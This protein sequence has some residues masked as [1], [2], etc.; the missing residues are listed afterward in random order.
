MPSFHEMKYVRKIREKGEYFFLDTKLVVVDR[1]PPIPVLGVAG[2][3]VK[4]TT[5]KRDQIF[6]SGGGLIENKGE[7]ETAPSSTFL[8][9]LNNH[10]LVYCKEVAGA[11]TISNFQSTSQKFM[12][13]RHAEFVNERYEEAKLER[14]LIPESERVSK[15][16][17]L[18]E[19]PY[20]KLRVT[21]LS[22]KESLKDFIARLKHIDSLAITLLPTNDE[23]IDNDDFWT[24]LGRRRREMNSKNAKVNFSNSSEGL[25]GEKVYE[26]AKAASNLA[27]SEVRLKGHD[28][29]G[30][31]LKGTNEDF[32]LTVEL[33]ELPRDTVLAA[34]V[35]YKQFDSLVKK[36]IIVIPKLV[37]GVAKKIMAIL[38]GL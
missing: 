7:L 26:Q 8:L 19:F 20:P 24:D 3:I 27:N 11:P 28:I 21:P 23:E 1:T 15:R 17:I 36:G 25:D 34:D 16:A 38:D 35:K 33:Q 6:R 13:L 12:K 9:I 31:T 10:R 29:L 18:E 5:L 37:D 4:N 22:D 32:S 30:D 2:R 14:V